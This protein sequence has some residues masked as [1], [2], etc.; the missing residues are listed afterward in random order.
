MLT[1]HALDSDRPAIILHLLL[2]LFILRLFIF[3]LFL[4]ILNALLLLHFLIL[5]HLF[6]NQPHPIS[7]IILF[8]I[9]IHHLLFRLHLQL[10]LSTSYSSLSSSSSFI[11]RCSVFKLTAN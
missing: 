7:I 2:R 6:P 1:C 4:C 3:H 8:F 5:L 9:I 10:L 11:S